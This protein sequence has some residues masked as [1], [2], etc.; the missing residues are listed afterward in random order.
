MAEV[1]AIPS[2]VGA[3]EAQVI[4][5]TRAY[6]ILLQNAAAERKQ[7]LALRKEIEDNLNTSLSDKRIIRQQ[8]ARYINGLR[9]DLNNYFY[10]YIL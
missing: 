10:Q 7:T 9:D 3:F 4:D 2:A 5:T 8:D 6:N 1:R